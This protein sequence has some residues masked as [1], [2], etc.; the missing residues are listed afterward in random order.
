MVGIGALSVFI[1]EE[2]SRSPLEVA[3]LGRPCLRLLNENLPSIRRAA[4]GSS[5]AS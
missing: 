1:A 2:L 3:K 5:C 4:D